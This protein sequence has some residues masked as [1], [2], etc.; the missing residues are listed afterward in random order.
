LLLLKVVERRA[1]LLGGSYH[2]APRGPLD[3][4]R[5]AV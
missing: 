5:G 2:C 3:D 1:T 4:L